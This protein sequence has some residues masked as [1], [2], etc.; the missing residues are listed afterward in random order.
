MK[1]LKIVSQT[2]AIAHIT[3][4][5]VVIYPEKDDRIIEVEDYADTQNVVQELKL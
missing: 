4:G 2:E 5:G 1:K 3:N